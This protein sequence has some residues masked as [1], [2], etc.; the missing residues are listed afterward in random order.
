MVQ[1]SRD[2]GQPG[3]EVVVGR[4]GEGCVLVADS[5]TGWLGMGHS[6]ERTMSG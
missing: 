3:A 4:E 6:L 2:G 5:V 1:M